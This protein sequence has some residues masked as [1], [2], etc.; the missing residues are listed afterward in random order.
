MKTF[1]AH[2]KSKEEEEALKAIL[3]A[4]KIKFEETTDKYP[5]S[6]EFVNMVVEAEQEIKE[7]KSI[8]VSLKGFDDLWK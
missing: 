8:K 3:K 4:L 5:Y 6:E 1:L 7:G 2:T